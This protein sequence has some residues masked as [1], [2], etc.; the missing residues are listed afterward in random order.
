MEEHMVKKRRRRNTKP[1]VLDAIEMM[2]LREPRPSA[3]AMR[4]ELLDTFSRAQVPGPKT[5]YEI[6]REITPADP[7][8]PWTLGSADA[9][10][11]AL[12]VPVL[13]AVVEQT[14]GQ[15]TQIT[16]AEAAWV[17]RIR[18]AAV[19]LPLDA[20]Y[21]LARVYMSREAH[22]ET[23]TDLDL[24]LSWGAWRDQETADRYF[25]AV[26]DGWVG[27]PPT[28]LANTAAG[29]VAKGVPRTSYSGVVQGPG[30]E[31][32]HPPAAQ[33]RTGCG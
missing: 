29:T 31:P 5:V 26:N 16:N 18:R 11:I 28:F 25:A 7:S 6:A 3:A 22:G 9:A 15:R 30:E 32:D 8:G 21:R 17:A 23:T 20:A 13:A 27:A 1:A 14:R 2:V 10:D 24:F 33:W 4:R 19:D 12:V